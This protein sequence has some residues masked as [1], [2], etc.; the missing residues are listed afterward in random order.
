MK[1]LLSIFAF[2]CTLSS[3]SQT[4]SKADKK[5]IR[6]LD[7]ETIYRLERDNLRLKT[8]L[9]EKNDSI[10]LLS[11]TLNQV[12]IS[13]S[14]IDAQLDSIRQQL[15]MDLVFYEEKPGNDSVFFQ[16]NKSLL[17]KGVYYRVQIGTFKTADSSLASS[18]Q[19][20]EKVDS[21]FKY[22]FGLFT[23]FNAA[24]SVKKDLQKLGIKDAWVVCY[25]NGARITRK[26]AKQI[27]S[28]RVD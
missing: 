28:E 7:A 6:K 25:F 24:N 12:S 1:Y 15:N 11:E 21:S 20:I 8:E 22:V 16:R 14:E 9:K 18:D 26:E 10:Q 19:G 2:L 23:E 27:E 5:R 3:F 4:L 17:P 13:I